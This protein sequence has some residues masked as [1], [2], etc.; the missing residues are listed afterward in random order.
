MVDPYG[1]V[2]ASLPLGEMGIVDANLPAALPATPY[3]RHGNT[4]FWSISLLLTACGLTSFRNR[5]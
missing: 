1:R 5:R 4:V 3:S 2:V